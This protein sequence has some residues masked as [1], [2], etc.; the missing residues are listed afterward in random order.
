[1]GLKSTCTS[2]RAGH[3]T[4]LPAGCFNRGWGLTMCAGMQLGARGRRPFTPWVRRQ[5][6]GQ[7]YVAVRLAH[8]YDGLLG[9]RRRRRGRLCPT[10]QKMLG[11]FS[12]SSQQCGRC[13]DLILHM[14]REKCMHTCIHA[15][16]MHAGRCCRAV[17]TRNKV[18]LFNRRNLHK[19]S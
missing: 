17:E 7:A 2:A 18:R 13:Q 8:K 4:P 16:R 12:V 10:Q 11:I 3:S 19:C 5:L 6:D 15:R 1:M 9:R 14:S